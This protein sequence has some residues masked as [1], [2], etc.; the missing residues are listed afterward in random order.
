MN[1][2]TNELQSRLAFF[3]SQTGQSRATR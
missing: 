1:A 3:N 2:E